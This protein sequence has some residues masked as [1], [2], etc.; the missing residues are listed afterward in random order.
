MKL[1]ILPIFFWCM[2]EVT[3]PVFIFFIL[4]YLTQPVPS[5]DEG[6]GFMFYLEKKIMELMSNRN[7]T[8]DSVRFGL[9]LH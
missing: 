3:P 2:K 7:Y 5:P 8:V 6:G 4:L 9:R 1:K